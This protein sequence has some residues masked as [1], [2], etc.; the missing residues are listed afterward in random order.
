MRATFLRLCITMWTPLSC[1]KVMS[2][3]R[4]TNSLR[5]IMYKRQ[6]YESAL[7]IAL[8]RWDGGPCAKILRY[9][10][11]LHLIGMQEPWERYLT[12]N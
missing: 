4:S 5:C 10:F 2:T 11:F 7:R 12:T 1:G 3:I 6:N 8:V 9:W